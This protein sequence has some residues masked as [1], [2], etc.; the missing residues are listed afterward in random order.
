MRRL[1]GRCLQHIMG[2]RK[3]LGQ[4]VVSSAL[5]AKP[6]TSAQTARPPQNCPSPLTS[7][8][9]LR[10]VVPPN[11]AHVGI[12]GEAVPALRHILEVR[13]KFTADSRV[14]CSPIKHHCPCLTHSLDTGDLTGVVGCQ[15]AH[16]VLHGRHLLSQRRE[17]RRRHLLGAPQPSDL[18]IYGRLSPVEDCQ[19]RF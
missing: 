2:L 15:R 10:L 18:L 3:S 5:L 16:S 11:G 7:G 8:Y 19:S 9:I 6:S 4:E 14:N 17:L 1:E 12:Q 13:F